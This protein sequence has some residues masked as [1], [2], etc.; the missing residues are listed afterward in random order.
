VRILERNISSLYT[1]AKL[2][3]ARKDAELTHLRQL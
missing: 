3:I 1:T 2:E